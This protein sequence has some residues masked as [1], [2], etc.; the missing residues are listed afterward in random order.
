MVP[1]GP[2]NLILGPNIRSIDRHEDQSK[3]NVSWD[4][5]FV[6]P[7][8]VFFH[9]FLSSS[10]CLESAFIDWEIRPWANRESVW[11]ISLSPF[12]SHQL[13]ADCKH[14]SRTH[15]GLSMAT[16]QTLVMK[17][18]A[19]HH[20]TNCRNRVCYLLLVCFTRP[21]LRDLKLCTPES[22]P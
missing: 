4:V 13:Q 16:V 11:F 7:S 15:R 19:A 9:S 20:V 6:L 14:V 10:R 17:P 18:W 3:P 8:C 22:G 21:K 5:A 2:E 1:A 12:V